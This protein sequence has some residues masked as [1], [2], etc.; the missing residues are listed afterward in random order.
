MSTRKRKQVDLAITK[1]ADELKGDK[2]EDEINKIQEYLYK[3][4]TYTVENKKFY[5]LPLSN[6][7]YI[8]KKGSFDAFE[9][10]VPSLEKVIISTV[11]QHRKEKETAFLLYLFDHTCAYEADIEAAMTYIG[12]FH[13]IPLL[14]RAGI[15]YKEQMQMVSRNYESEIE[16][17]NIEIDKL[18]QRIEEL[19]KELAEYRDRE[20]FYVFG[21]SFDERIGEKNEEIMGLKSRITE[22]EKENF[23]LRDEVYELRRKLSNLT[24]K[25]KSL[26]KY[27]YDKYKKKYSEMLQSRLAE[28]KAKYEEEVRKMNEMMASLQ[29]ENQRLLNELNELRNKKEN[30]H[31]DNSIDL[32]IKD[33][34]I[35]RLKSEIEKIKQDNLHFQ[36]ELKSKDKIIQNKDNEIQKLNYKLAT[37]KRNINEYQKFI[38]ENDKK[39]KMIESLQQQIASKDQLLQ[40]QQNEIKRLQ[41]IINNHKPNDEDSNKQE[42]KPKLHVQMSGSYQRIPGIG[43]KDHS[44]SSSDDESQ[45]EDEDHP[46][47]EDNNQK[48]DENEEGNKSKT[49]EEND[50]ENEDP[51][52]LMKEE[53]DDDNK[54]EIELKDDEDSVILEDN[55]DNE[56]A[57]KEE[58]DEPIEPILEFKEEEDNPEEVIVTPLQEEEDTNNKMEIC[59]MIIST[60]TEKGYEI[61]QELLRQLQELQ[62]ENNK[63]DEE[64]KRLKLELEKQERYKNE[65]NTKLKLEIE[66]Q[67]REK[68]E[69]I[70]KLRQKLK[71]KINN[72]DILSDSDFPTEYNE[73]D[74]I[75]LIDMNQLTD[76]SGS[77]LYSPKQMKERELMFQDV[78]KGN[79][80]SI[81]QK[82]NDGLDVNMRNPFKQTLL[83]TACEN[84]HLNVAKYLVE[85]QHLSL[86]AVDNTGMTPLGSA[87][88]N[89]HF[90]IVKYLVKQ[91]AN[92][93]AKD[94]QN[95]TPLHI[96]CMSGQMPIVVFL[97]E[98]VGAKTNEMDKN[99]DTPFKIAQKYNH[100]IICQYLM[101]EKKIESRSIQVQRRKKV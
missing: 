31:S 62:K 64:N 28:M 89:G 70:E 80:T 21:D 10:I 15:L 90:E 43:N 26:H 81:K 61:P 35:N 83:H 42:E 23:D 18:K 73:E 101:P 24:D 66:K 14:Y 5:T 78:E 33:D 87:C 1:L 32:Q 67:R 96:A 53:D 8:L 38:E 91:N 63:K 27:L 36:S 55:D 39:H 30:N 16:E 46:H 3:Q 19:E 74:R 17:K 95:R 34:E 75:P 44:S 49:L 29:A 11:E 41:E 98:K 13:N 37:Y 60:F 69:E 88:Y 6:I 7:N 58:D 50:D 79:L 72:S 51:F 84:G 45:N 85:S 56:D 68:D 100:T 25:F 92:K 97:I 94:L 65:E 12:S 57:E 86:E 77:Y 4:I 99:G 20:G 22:L 93:E 52:V 2:R 59:N 48:D 71:N 40:D 54:N 82:I 76:L 9:E 47:N